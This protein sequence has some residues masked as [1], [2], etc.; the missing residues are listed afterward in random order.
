MLSYAGDSTWRTMIL[1]FHRTAL[2][3][4]NTGTL[5]FSFEFTTLRLVKKHEVIAFLRATAY[6]L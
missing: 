6:M 1:L 5:K 3:I 4:R 2:Q